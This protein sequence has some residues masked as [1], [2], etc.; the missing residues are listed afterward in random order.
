V[1][2]VIEIF[3]NNEGGIMKRFF[4]LLLGLALVFCFQASRATAESTKIGVVDLD[5]FQKTSKVF[6][7]TAA[8]MKKKYEELQKKLDEERDALTKLD[9]EFKKQSMMLSL[10][11]Q[12]DKKREL[13]KKRRYVKYLYDEYTQDMK[14]TETEAM[15]K[16]MKELEKVVEKLGEKE[17]FT[18]ILEKRTLGLVYYNKAVDITD[19]VIDAY[20]KMYQ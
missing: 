12:E 14:D 8:A 1:A 2:R 20:D 16:I 7:K 17:G 10:D 13:D 5:K 19:R 18:A 3:V 4:F 9:E 15:K 11:A 6:Q